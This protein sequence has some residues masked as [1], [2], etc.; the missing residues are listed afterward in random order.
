MTSPHCTKCGSERTS[1]TE[2]KGFFQ[3]VVA[4]RLG[5]FPWECHACWKTFLSTARGKRT[6]RNDRPA[7]ST[8]PLNPRISN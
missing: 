7:E 3:E 5:L 2:R 1:R 4:Y 6:R 8:A